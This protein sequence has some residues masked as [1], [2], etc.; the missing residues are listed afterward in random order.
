[1]AAKTS[2]KRGIE[3]GDRVTL[4]DVAREANVSTATV[5]K[6]LSGTKAAIRIS[7]ST[8]DRVLEVTRRLN[9]TPNASAQALRRG[10]LR[11]VGLFFPLGLHPWVSHVYSELTRSINHLLEEEKHSLVILIN[12]HETQKIE[13]ELKFPSFIYNHGVD[14]VIC[15]HQ[16]NDALIAELEQRG[17]P[18]VFLNCNASRPH[19]CVDADN[20]SLMRQ[21]MNYVYGLGHRR[22]LYT[23]RSIGHPSYDLKQQ[24]Y[25]DF[26]RRKKL[27]VY[28]PFFERVA[29]WSEEKGD[30]GEKIV[31]HILTLDDPPTAIVAY[32]DISAIALIHALRDRNIAIPEQISIVGC[33]DIQESLVA[34]PRLTTYRFP[35]E[36]IAKAAVTMIMQQI[37]D[38]QP[39]DSVLLKH[40]FVERE[41]CTGPT[42]ATAKKR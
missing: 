22:I 32:N 20:V 30:Y 31:D 13:E 38:R 34:R 11:S 7:K 9:F 35:T 29:P 1:M 41:S 14:G 33:D 6:V 8:R 15:V 25:E 21:T 2:A 17:I 18:H 28:P 19:N 36:A 37:K 23:G 40:E 27:T 26:M 39:Q 10:R 24:V 3:S 4:R 12:P 42:P 5:S 16:I